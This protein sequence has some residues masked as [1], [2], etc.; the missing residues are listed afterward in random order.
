MRRILAMPLFVPLALL[1]L[2]LLVFGDVLTGLRHGVLSDS[3]TDLAT[4]FYYWRQF[5]FENLRHGHIA[6]WNPY[7]CGGVPFFGGW[8]SGLLYPINWI[9]LFLPLP[10]A[11]NLDIVISTYLTGLFTSL[12]ARKYGLS[13]LARLLAAAIVML[14]GS[15]FPHVYAGHLATM[16]AMAWMPLIVLAFDDLIDSPNPRSVLLAIFSFSMQLFA[17]HPQTLFNTLVVLAL[18]T[19]LRI[20]RARKR[21]QTAAA[22]AVAA[23]GSAAITAVQLL[24]GLEVSTEGVRSH[25]VGYAFA[26][27]I[28]YQAVNLWTLLVPHLFGDIFHMPYWGPWN[29]WEMCAFI[30]VASL[31]LVILGAFRGESPRRKLWITMAIALFVLAMGAYTPLFRLLYLYVP[32][33]SKFRA[34]AKFIFPVTIFT[35][36][37]AGAGLDA[38]VARREEGSSGS[39]SRLAAATAGVAAMCA[40]AGIWMADPFTCIWFIRTL[41]VASDSYYRV[42][43][44]QFTVFAREAGRFAAWGFATATLTASLAAVLLA[45]A[46]STRWAAPTLATLV[47]VELIAFDRSTI[48][49]F[50]PTHPRPAVVM[51]WERTHPGDQRVYLAGL[52]TEGAMGSGSYDVWGY[53][54]MVQL[55]YA[56]LVTATQHCDANQAQMYVMY[57]DPNPSLALL[58]C[59][60]VFFVTN[61]VNGFTYVPRNKRRFTADTV[62]MNVIDNPLPHGLIVHRCKIMPAS[63]KI[64][65]KV[66]DANFPRWRVVVLETPPSIAP[67]PA[68]IQDSAQVRWKDSDTLEVNAKCDAPGIL[69]ITDAYSRFW[70]ANALPSSTQRVYRPMPGDY[71]LI[72]VPLEAGTH[73]FELAYRP[74]GLR[75][76]AA[77]SLAG[78]AAYLLACGLT[79]RLGR[80]ARSVGQSNLSSSL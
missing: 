11:C 55:R 75:K 64:L 26:A 40:M 76:G 79:W 7:V 69:L 38:L 59:S 61:D 49:T 53:D 25:A 60:R 80:Q 14:G 39:G 45:R 52:L 58:R 19:G 27:E 43:I 16:A 8:Q 35:A 70:I 28:S 15:F 67:R 78:L 50:D 10:V 5:G 57:T 41:R 71:A 74:P 48:T 32:G 68:L 54:P 6:Q 42:S 33:F 56:Q 44:P 4:E 24:A 12:L 66:A 20:I 1:A 21:L 72:A 62:G 17:G 47:L 73:R 22:I 37:L 2:C 34:F 18:Y 13:P 65:Y 63:T 23:A 30:G 31:P 36:M 51:N 77:I 46:R 3:T 29:K 9:Y